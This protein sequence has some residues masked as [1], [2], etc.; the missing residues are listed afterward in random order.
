MQDE[1]DKNDGSDDTIIYDASEFDEVNN[2]TQKPVNTHTEEGE[3]SPKG[4]LRTQIYGII[5]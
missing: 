2:P 4:Q 5:K 1:A 3:K